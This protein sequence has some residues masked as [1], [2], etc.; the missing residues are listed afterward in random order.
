MATRAIAGRAGWFAGMAFFLLFFA[1]PVVWLILATTKSD[2]D[3]VRGHPF[4]IGSWHDFQQTWH[5]LL[6][7]QDGA[8]VLWM[9]NSAIYA[10]GALALTLITAIPAG[11]G[12]AL[13]QF[14]GRKTLLS[15]TLIV[16]IM[17]A[18]ALVLPLYLEINAIGLTGTIWSV[19]LPLS[20]FP[21]GVYLAYIYYSSTVPSD[22]LAAARLDG[23]S[24]WQVF[25]H[26]A[27]PLARPVIALVSF[28]SFVGNWNNFFLPFVMLPD[29]QQYPAQVGLS[30]LLTA[31]AVFNTSAGTESQILRPELALAALFTILPVLLVFLFSQRA[32]VSGMLAGGTKE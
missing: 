20:F 23:C 29:S 16:M 14:I 27:L 18:A 25:R 12:L 7:F 26:I 28:F 3:I 17:P 1:L 10:F 32:L 13:T 19:I 5:N 24:E 22:L 9:K 15:I 8:I 6:N 11:Y 4:A 21:F 2:A 30:N 31:S